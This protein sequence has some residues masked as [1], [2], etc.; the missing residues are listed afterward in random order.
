MAT[1]QQFQLPNGQLLDAETITNL[2]LYSQETTPVDDELLNS[3]L[4]R[5]ELDISNVPGNATN[6]SNILPA[7]AKVANILVDALPYM[8]SGPGRFANGSQFDL[9]RAFFGLGKNEMLTSDGR[10]FLLENVN[11]PPGTYNKDQIN[12]FLFQ[13]GTQDPQGNPRG[14]KGFSSSLELRNYRDN[15]STTDAD[16]N[17]VSE[18]AELIYIWNSTAFAI[19]DNAR[20]VVNPNGTKEI[21]NFVIQPNLFQNPLSRENFD[22]ATANPIVEAGS[23]LLLEP[24][25]DPSNIGR[26]VFIDFY[27][28]QNIPLHDPDGLFSPGV[29]NASDFQQDLFAEANNFDPTSLGVIPQVRDQ[30]FS[31]FE[32]GVTKFIFDD[33]Q[34]FYGTI[35]DDILTGKNLVN[36]EI[37]SAEGNLRDVNFSNGLVLLGGQGNDS[38]TGDA[39]ADIFLGATDDILAGHEGNDTLNGN[40]GDDTLNGGVGNDSLDGGEGDADT[41]IFSDDFDAYDPSI[42]ADE[43]ITFAHN[44]GTQTDGTDTLQNIEFAQFANREV[45]LRRELDLAFVVDTTVSMAGSISIVILIQ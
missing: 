34:I 22:F 32:E 23:E 19:P 13:A 21:Q 28:R 25:V 44:R 6:F 45:D 9:V 38:L 4:I 14:L 42:S 1:E 40:G 10:N 26:Q 2:Y 33:K 16:G 12:G 41:A 43:T 3:N 36:A 7:N 17:G 35:G 8:S 20:F 24:L 5:P 11:I 18:Y 37:Q 39:F 31:L 15:L 29:Y 30:A 27:G